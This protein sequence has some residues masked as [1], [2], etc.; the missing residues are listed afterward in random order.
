M[1]LP[2]YDGELLSLAHDLAARLLPAFDDTATGI[3]FPR[4]GI[5]LAVVGFC[6]LCECW[7][8][9]GQENN[10]SIYNACENDKLVS[11]GQT[12]QSQIFY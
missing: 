9:W 8:R 1:A 5:A 2:N 3:P 6:D 11:L 4:V 12:V 7:F 10:T